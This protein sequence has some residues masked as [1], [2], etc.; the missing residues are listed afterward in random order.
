MRC[1]RAEWTKCTPHT[2]RQ[3]IFRC[4]LY[5]FRS[6]STR[7]PWWV[8]SHYCHSASPRQVYQRS[9]YVWRLKF[10]SVRTVF[11]AR[12]AQQR[13]MH[14]TR[15]PTPAAAAQ[16]ATA[17]LCRPQHRKQGLHS[18]CFASKTSGSVAGLTLSQRQPR[19]VIGC[20]RHVTPDLP[21]PAVSLV[22]ESGFRCLFADD[23]PDTLHD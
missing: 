9:V 7:P 16:P 4:H 8:E 3:A 14:C 1:M 18:S 12:R 19:S 20:R 13:C 23:A 2:R 5:P 6:R 15:H 10:A 22:G 17:A 11:H 21:T